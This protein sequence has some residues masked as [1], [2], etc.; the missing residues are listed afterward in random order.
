VTSRARRTPVEV[1]GGGV[2]GQISA[3]HLVFLVEEELRRY[4]R[5]GILT[6]GFRGV[7]CSKCRQE[8]VV[9]LSC[10][11]RRA[12]PSCSLRT[13]VTKTFPL[14]EAREAWAQSMTGHTHG[15][16]VLDVP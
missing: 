2:N 5:C 4:L 9:A 1:R 3:T 14:A 7:V 12:C 8:I 11:C 6:H 16:L 10:K 15:K 13:V